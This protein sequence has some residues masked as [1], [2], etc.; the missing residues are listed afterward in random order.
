[1][2]ENTSDG[3][4][5]Q[6][7]NL[8]S[9]RLYFSAPRAVADRDIIVWRANDEIAAISPLPCRDFRCRRYYIINEKRNII[10][11]HVTFIYRL[12]RHFRFGPTRS[13]RE[14]I[15]NTITIYDGRDTQQADSNIYGNAH[16]S[17]SRHIARRAP[18]LRDIYRCP[19][20]QRYLFSR[21]QPYRPHGAI[22]LKHATIRR[23]V[24]ASPASANACRSAFSAT[25][26]YTRSLRWAAERE[27]STAA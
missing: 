16:L 25:S 12:R 10:S 14:L 18:R 1:M 6:C 2:I 19:S 9:C 13:D 22:A 4:S 7:Q 8:L 15:L 24:T 27:Q 26:E 17:I 3:F 5:S 20:A 23:F 11:R 21:Y